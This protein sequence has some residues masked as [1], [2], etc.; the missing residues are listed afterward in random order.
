MTANLH[1]A[2]SPVPTKAIA[3]IRVARASADTESTLHRQL[4]DVRA[5][6]ASYGLDITREFVD[7]GW[8]GTTTERPGIAAL[9]DYI[10]EGG[11]QTCVVESL[12]KVARTP[13]AFAHICEQLNAHGVTLVS[14]KDTVPVSA[15]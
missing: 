7:F 15:R 12:S 2:A 14:R 8:S 1:T 9:L 10:G 13:K 11:T 3:Y 4:A 5:R 6:A